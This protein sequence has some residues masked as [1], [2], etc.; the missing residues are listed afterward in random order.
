MIPNN[1]REKREKVKRTHMPDLSDSHAG[2]AVPVPRNQRAGRNREVAPWK[3]LLLLIAG[4]AGGLTIFRF[5]NPYWV[6]IDS[7][8]K[9]EQIESGFAGESPSADRTAGSQEV[10]R[11]TAPEISESSGICLSARYPGRWWTHNDNGSFPGLFLLESSGELVAWID[12]KDAPFT[13]WEAVTRVDVDGRSLIAI[14]DIGD[15]QARRDHCR[16]VVIEEPDIDEAK[17]S[18]KPV[19]LSASP[20]MTV[21]F[22]WPDGAQDCESMAYDPEEKEF[23]FVSKQR[24]ATALESLFNGGKSNEI[25]ASVYRLSWSPDRHSKDE[26]LVA[27]KL[28]TPFSPLMSTGMDIHSGGRKAVVRNYWAAFVFE[29]PA[30]VSWSETFSKPPSNTFLFPAQRQG[31]AVAFTADGNSVLLTS[32]GV[33]QPVLKVDVPVPVPSLREKQEK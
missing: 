14:G 29:R 1:G 6:S 10:G 21:L 11:L 2:I 25:R 28:D 32:E 17:N 27:A 4:V 23:W 22:R 15:N 9:A 33:D 16:I 7:V 3:W 26:I 20:A 5:A 18:D 12:I 13:D 19:R 24:P 31:E 30:G 8:D